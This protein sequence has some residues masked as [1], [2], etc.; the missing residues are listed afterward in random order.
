MS[1]RVVFI[2]ANAYSINFHQTALVWAL[3]RRASDWQCFDVGQWFRGEIS[4]TEIVE[5]AQTADALVLHSSVFS[6]R[7]NKAFNEATY[8]VAGPV[9][10]TEYSE[11]VCDLLCAH[12]P[13]VWL[14][15]NLDLHGDFESLG[16]RTEQFQALASFYFP[17][18]FTARRDMEKR[19]GD[20][21]MCQFRAPEEGYER[22]Q[23]I[24]VQ[25]ENPFCL[26]DSE[27]PPRMLPKLWGMTTPGVS[28]GRRKLARDRQSKVQRLT[29]PYVFAR[30][31]R[32]LAAVQYKTT[33]WRLPNRWSIDFGRT[34]HHAIIARSH[35]AYTEGSAYDYPVRKFIEIPAQRTLLM[36]TPHPGFDDRGFREGETHLEVAPEDV[37]R[38]VKTLDFG[39]AAVRAIVQQGFDMVRRLHHADARADQLIGAIDLF[40]AGRLKAACFEGG[41]YTYR[42]HA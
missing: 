20:P 17:N 30:I 1:R 25:I 27:F 23:K 12:A 28:Y 22:L 10:P 26:D 35:A 33:G 24:P 31:V 6:W 8:Y 29:Q 13:R 7:Y 5:A 18:R 37:T 39:G 38:L 4:R 42:T 11:F 9:A 19:L 2:Y 32:R 40:A 3:S 16:I 34:L 15:D 21:W 14:A 41:E 36:C